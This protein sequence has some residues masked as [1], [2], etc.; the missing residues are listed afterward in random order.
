MVRPRERIEGFD[1]RRCPRAWL[2]ESGPTWRSRKRRT[3]LGFARI[4]RQGGPGKDLPKMRKYDQPG[5][6]A[7]ERGEGA[8]E[9]PATIRRDGGTVGD[10]ASAGGQG[11]A[12]TGPWAAWSRSSRLDRWLMAVFLVLMI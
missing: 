5:R 11:G 2:P 1:H 10:G 4:A 6:P 8:A 3:G 12:G 9:R 7:T